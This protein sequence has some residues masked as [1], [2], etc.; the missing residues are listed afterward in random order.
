M[1][2][3]RSDMRNLRFRITADE[4]LDSD[5]FQLYQAEVLLSNALSGRTDPSEKLGAKKIRNG[6]Q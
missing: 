4:F 1:S 3:L 5:W 2:S 6:Q